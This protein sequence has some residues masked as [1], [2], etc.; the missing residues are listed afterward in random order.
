MLVAAYR[1]KSNA[2]RRR[3]G[4]GASADRRISGVVV[5]AVM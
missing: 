5:S 1:S 2:D 3:R 4:G